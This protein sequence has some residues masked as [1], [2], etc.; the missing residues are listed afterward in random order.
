M[1]INRILLACAAIAIPKLAFADLP[2]ATDEF[3]KLETTLK[4]CAELQPES[5]AKYQAIAKR[6]VGNVPA[7]DLAKARE[8]PEYQQAYETNGTFLANLPKERVIEACNSFLKTK[9]LR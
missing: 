5:A 2:F 7:K 3:G 4:F 6:Y 9:D 8:T 1:K